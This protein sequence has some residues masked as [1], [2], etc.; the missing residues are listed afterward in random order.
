M[1]ILAAQVANDI[2]ARGSSAVYESELSR[3]WP[4]DGREH[5]RRVEA[6]AREHGWC[7]RHYRDGFV[8][9]FEKEPPEQPTPSQQS[10]GAQLAIFL[11]ERRD[12]IVSDCIAAV[13]RDEKVP[14][15]DTLTQTQLRDDLP[16]ILDNLA[17]VLNGAFSQ[18]LKQEAAWTAG[19]AVT[20]VGR[21]TTI[22]LSCSASLT[23]SVQSSF[24][25]SSNSKASI[26][27]PA[28]RGSLRRQLCTVTLTMRFDHP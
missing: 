1:H 18:E 23:T 12:Q 11:S 25:T 2:A 7:V 14:T 15:S 6:F 28:L 5:E 10:I 21:N 24:A 8:A 17:M 9:I 27:L 13:E 20:S 4:K 26:K 22:F 19:L 3:V 16:Q